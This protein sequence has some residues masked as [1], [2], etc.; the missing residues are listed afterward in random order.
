MG[1]IL[2]VVLALAGLGAGAG[3]GCAL[4]PDL[5][6]Q[7]PAAA[8]PCDCELADPEAPPPALPGE[9]GEPGNSD[10]VK[11]NNQFVVPIVAR[12]TVTAMV[13]L[14]L[15]LQVHTGGGEA[16][17]QREPKLRDQFL[18]VLF[19]HANS[20]GFDGAFTAGPKMETLRGA[21][22]AA[23]RNILGD[24]VQDVLI[25]DIARQDY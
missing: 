14:S 9:T 12:E 6:A 11:L 23:A 7:E 21:L 1:K 8:C 4:R 25:T 17:Y 2:P 3:A 16:V 20:G 18:R 10:F 15:S 24:V 22:R 19:D 5:A 13:V